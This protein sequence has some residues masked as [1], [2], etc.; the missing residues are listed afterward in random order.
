[1]MPDHSVHPL[2]VR[3]IRPGP[4]SYPLVSPIVG[5]IRPMTG[6]GPRV[7][8]ALLALV[9]LVA[10]TPDAAQDR[11]PTPGAATTAPARRLAL[12]VGNDTYP[13]TPLKN[14]R[15]DARAMAQALTDLGFR[16]TTLEDVTRAR[17]VSG[18]AAF[19][20]NLQ[21]S[22]LALFFYAGH[23]KAV[24]NENFLLPTD[25]SGGSPEEVRLGGVAASEVERTLR[26]AR[27]RVLVLDAC[28]DNAF[29]GTRAVGGGLSPMQ[30][31]GSL[32]AFATRANE[33]AS[34]NVSGANG[35]FT[36]ELVRVLR[37]PGLTLRE[38]FYRVRERVDV[39]SAGRQFPALYDEL[40]TDVILRASAAAVTTAAPDSTS[41]FMALQ[42]ELALWDAIKDSRSTAVFEDYLKRYPSGQFRVPAEERLS[43]ARAAVGTSSPVASPRPALLPSGAGGRR[44][45]ETRRDPIVGGIEWAW[46][47]AGT[48]EMGCTPGDFSCFPNESP[49]HTVTLSRAFG[50]MTTEVTVA[51]VRAVFQT[52]PSQ[53]TWSLNDSPVVNITWNDARG[54][55]ESLMGRL[56]TEAEWEYAARGGGL[57]PYPWGSEEP[58]ATPGAGHGARFSSPSA[59]A[60]V[61]SYGP[62]GF[63]LYDTAGNVWEWVADWSG[64][65]D[66]DAQTDPR[67]PA[68]GPSRVLRGG[69]WASY[70]GSL[71][72]SDRLNLASTGR[73]DSAGVRCARDVSP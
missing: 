49:R 46:I 70:P 42:V 13:A 69:S 34:D 52:I 31:R 7:V 22:D 35:L 19:A 48:F 17:F 20:G 28:R 12:V 43:A 27:V 73:D 32:V 5:I 65:Y 55:C 11:R 9:V 3:L 16:V 64:P 62:N 54:V 10:A 36:A 2:T 30:A 33:T 56:P 24:D 58:V 41:A 26:A 59:A 25:V 18:L 68:S 6:R 1:M 40:S 14:A 38:I 51:M 4:F 61:A 8:V 39:A 66:P 71:R 45:G 23:G 63:G 47:P 57:G 44:A 53:P 50:M 60:P 37:E 72:V 21:T 29:G 67:G 15:N